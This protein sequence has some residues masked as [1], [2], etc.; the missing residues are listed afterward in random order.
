IHGEVQRLE[1]LWASKETARQSLYK[2][3][4][5]SGDGTL[6]FM[7]RNLTLDQ[8]LKSQ[9]AYDKE[10]LAL[11]KNPKLDPELV[12]ALDVLYGYKETSS[13]QQDKLA[14][15]RGLVAVDVLIELSQ[16]RL[17]SFKAQSAGADKV[18]AAAQRLDQYRTLKDRWSSGTSDLSSVY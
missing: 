4:L 8:Y 10:L 15:G 6:D 1:K 13:R 14:H 12:R 5:A 18:M 2:E 11:F 7:V 3:Y 17:N 9:E 16:A